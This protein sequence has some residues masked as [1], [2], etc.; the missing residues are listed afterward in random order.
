MAYEMRISD[1][2]SDVCSSDLNMRRGRLETVVDRDV[3]SR[4]GKDAD[5]VESHP[6]GIPS[7][8]GR[9]Q[10]RVRFQLLARFE[11]HNDSVIHAFNPLVE[12]GRASCTDSVCQYV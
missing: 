1:W 3:A 12:L 7:P 11:V 4:I 10:E 8:A 2:S 5:R 6:V 9:P